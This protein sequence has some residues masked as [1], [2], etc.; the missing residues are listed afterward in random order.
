MDSAGLRV[1]AAGPR[2]ALALDAVLAVAPGECLALAG[3]SGAGKTSLL[4]AVA[5]LWRPARGRVAL[6]DALWLDTGAGIDLPPEER[7]CGL[8]FQDYALFPHLS[9]WRNVAYGME[10]RTP[11]PVLPSRRHRDRDGRRERALAL[12]DSFGLAQRAEA[13]PA[14]LSGGE[15]QRVA[16]ARALARDPAVL[17][18]AEPLAALDPA[19]RA[20]AAAELAG[21]L[22]A[23]RV[24]TLLVTHAFAEAAL[25]GDRVAVLDAGRLVQVGTPGELAAA[26]AS[27]WVADLTGAVVLRG[28][29]VAEPGGLTRVDLDGGGHVHAVDPGTGRVAVTLHPWEIALEPLDAGSAGSARNR[30]AV[31][32]VAV[33]E[34]G[35]RARVGLLAGGRDVVLAAEVTSASARA[36]DLHPGARV[37]ATWKAAATRL[38]PAGGQGSP[39]VP[40]AGP[41]SRIATHT[42]TGPAR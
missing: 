38:V 24:P 5:G 34:L 21:V 16:L 28:V 35:A 27:A 19:P 42:P 7:A 40:E 4:R 23:T 10:A 29:A 11:R 22:R 32:G 25:L 6:G 31:E 12:L 37:V 17:L 26:P 3:P 2:G 20:G 15:R 8:V 9:A 1:E 39:G 33:T 36:L 18:L 14:E 41:Q 13:R 30:L